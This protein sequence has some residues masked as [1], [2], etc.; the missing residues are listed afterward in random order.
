MQINEQ[1][2]LSI[3]TVCKDDLQGLMKTYN[4]LREQE[5]LNFDR[6]EWI[7][8]DGG[9]IDGTVEFIND[10]VSNP[11]IVTHIV[12]EIDNCIYDAM[13]IGLKNSNGK[14]VQFLNSQ[15]IYFDTKSLSNIINV[16]KNGEDYLFIYGGHEDVFE[17][18]ESIIK[19]PR[20]INYLNWGLPTSHQAIFY[21]QKYKGDIKYNLNFS[22]S[23]DYQFT[24][25]IYMRNKLIDVYIINKPIIK[26]FIGGNSTQKKK[27]LLKDCYNIQKEIL[28]RS[29]L[30]AI[31]DYIRRW[32]ALF[33]FHT[34]IKVYKLLRKIIK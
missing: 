28:L 21:N 18:G 24:A 12:D 23:A 33:F 3:I 1:P 31:I 2:L 5:D 30:L 27:E 22:T 9:S 10:I 11:L 7:I 15:D 4:S 14:Y 25:E 32:L 13:N 17:N 6:I 29:N 34:F 19:N 20:K 16:L 26:F 8:K